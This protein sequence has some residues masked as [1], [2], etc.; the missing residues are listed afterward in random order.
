M[1]STPPHSK[2]ERL[3]LGIESSCDECSASVIAH[4]PSKSS[5]TPIEVRS[6]ITHSQ[7]IIHQPYGGVVPEIA[8]RNHLETINTV[9]DQALQESGAKL[10]SLDAIAVT[11]RPGLAG[12]L[13]VG[14]SA[15][16]ALAYVSQKPLVAIHHLEGHAASIFLKK[17]NDHHENPIELPLLLAIIS[18]GHTNLY[19]MTVFPELWP[20]DF[21]KRS[22]VGRSRDDAAGEAF[23]K[24]AKI[25]G[26]PYPGG[27]WIDKMAKQGNAK[28]FSFPR[29]LPQKATLDF[30]FSGLKTAVAL[31][32][33]KLKKQNQLESKI[34]DLCASIQEAIVDAIFSKIAIAA[35]E[36]RCRS[37]AIVGGV[38][39]NSHLRSRINQEWQ[40]LGFVRPPLFPGSQYCTDNAAM[41][42]AAGWFRYRQGYTLKPDELLTLNAIPNPEV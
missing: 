21:L 20:L 40:P 27:A 39:A 24:T 11:N 1:I 12:A 22:L 23:D 37:L 19:V 5:H 25:L 4:H 17:S 29:A 34:P 28:A 10:E 36:N 16:K 32:V 6:L 41:I 35:R 33:E 8:S 13:L 31:E 3:I 18:G 26:F 2:S 42:A 9:I 38:A 14:V 15:A 30:S 7:I